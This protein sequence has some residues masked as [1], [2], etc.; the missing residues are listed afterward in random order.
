MVLGMWSV[1]LRL[2][3][4]SFVKF[5]IFTIWCVWAK[6]T[7]VCSLVGRLLDVGE[8]M[9]IL[10]RDRTDVI[11]GVYFGVVA[12]KFGDLVVAIEE[13]SLCVLLVSAAAAAT[14]TLAW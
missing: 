9:L 3:V 10:R 13:W 1:I 6:S 4:L 2:S 7:M 11:K 14:T 12:C 8:G 5:K